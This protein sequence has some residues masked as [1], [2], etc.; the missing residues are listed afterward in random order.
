MLRSRL[1]RV[2]QTTKFLSQFVRLQSTNSSKVDVSSE[3]YSS[4]YSITN[5]FADLDTFSKRHLGPKP[6]DVQSMLK[7]VNSTN[8]SDFIS[9][10][11]PEKVF[12]GRKLAVQPLNGYSETEMVDRLK[13]LASKNKVYRSYIGKGY[14][15]T[16]LPLVIQ[17]N[18]LENPAWYTSYTP[19]Q[20]EVSQGRL[21]SLL[22]FQTVVSD[23][24]GLPVSNA[25]LLDE[26]TAAAEA[27]IMSYNYTRGKKNIY[28]VDSNIHEQTYSVLMSRSNTLDIEIK[29]IDLFSNEGFQNLK[30]NIDNTCGVLVSYPQSNGA[31]PSIKKLQD[32]SNLVHSNK[33]LFSVT[34]DLLALT[35]LHPPSSFGADIVLGSS[36]RFGVPMGFGGPHAAFFSVTK[37]LQRKMPGRLIGIT[38]DRLNKPALRLALQTREQHIKREKATSNICTAQALLANIASNY[39]VYHG[40]DGLRNISNKIYGF[41]SLLANE[42]KENTSHTIVNDSWFDTLS[43]KLNGTTADALLKRAVDDYGINLFKVNESTVQLSLDETVAQKDLVD[44][45][46]L[47]TGKKIDLTDVKLPELPN[48]LMRKDVILS[49]PVFNKYHSETA[50]LRYLYSLQQKDISLASSMISL[51][52]CTMK[53]NATVEMVSLTWP[54]FGNLHPFIPRDQ[55]RGY[56]ELIEELEAD[57]ADITGFHK[58]TLMPNSGAQGEYTGLSVIKQFLHVIKGETQRNIVLIPVSAHG[59]NPASATMAGFKVV[60]VKCLSNGNLDLTDLQKQADKYSDKLAAMMV[61]YPSTY[62]LF[63]PTIIDACKIIHEH[64]GQVYLDG[65]NMNAQVG[66]TSPGDLGADVCHLNLHKTFAIPHGGGGPG[67]GPI[68]VA[69][70]LSDL[71]PKHPL[72]A[73]SNR[74]IDNAIEPVASAPF[75]SASILTIPYAY[76]KSMGGNNIPFSSA[77]AILN[78]NYMMY[79]LKDAYKI[80]FLGENASNTQSDDKINYCAHEFIIDIRPFKSIHIEAIDVAKRL[81]DYG[82]HA[83]TM[84]FP[85]PGTLM[86]EPTESEN[87]EELDRF[88]NAMLSI[89]EEIRQVEN[90]TSDGAILKNAP[91][92]LTD[93]LETSEEEWSKRGYTREQA[94]F[95]LPYLKNFK[96]WPTVARVDDTY[97]DLN[98]QCTC[99][100]VEEV[101]NMQI[102]N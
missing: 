102:E 59:T 60:P 85:I 72:G 92:P 76:I 80:M 46:E 57:L 56:M 18:L 78:A 49:N 62:G 3:K 65:A 96:T 58:T 101:A 41:T 13:E 83:P 34:S 27:M 10:V 61:T 23:L 30:E 5:Q 43:I 29:V 81:Q 77:T 15:G 93:L 26:G 88:I 63:E 24:T 7:D 19:Y 35:L 69:E 68:C 2:N 74:S 95:P 12:I 64:G 4:L 36:Q 42:I 52:S 91:H 28:Y 54:E 17:R 100:T 44:L 66:L 94:G 45:I 47:F 38:K 90:G 39:A 55:A 32:I 89:R 50:M 84:S 86:V 70:H 87:K 33:G 16:K 6:K 51:G 71:L 82:F 21:E 40:L 48:E 9:K 25:S 8:M 53:L 79:R 73:T 14:Y 97:G 1:S 75:G 11:I 67:V 31:L 20:A 22:N 98:I 99:P 37:A